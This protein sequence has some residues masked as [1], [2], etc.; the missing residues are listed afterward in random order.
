METELKENKIEGNYFGVSGLVGWLILVQIGIYGT[1]LLNGITFTDF[2]P[3]FN[4]ETWM[5][6]TSKQ[7]EFYHVSYYGAQHSYLKWFTTLY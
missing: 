7:S 1:L 4:Q 6:F 2:I 3:I 5:M